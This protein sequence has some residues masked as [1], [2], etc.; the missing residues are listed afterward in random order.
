MSG[1]LSVHNDDSRNC[2]ALDRK[3]FQIIPSLISSQKPH[4]ESSHLDTIACLV[5][6]HTF[7]CQESEWCVRQRYPTPERRL[8]CF[9]GTQ[10]TARLLA[11]IAGTLACNNCDGRCDAANCLA[12]SALLRGMSR[13]AVLRNLTHAPHVN[14]SDAFSSAHRGTPM[15]RRHRPKAA[16]MLAG[17]LKRCAA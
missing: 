10:A 7:S 6:A 12:I 13:I 16:P 1:R 8:T 4:P 17:A 14:F 2:L 9:V 15:T 11:R 3:E 5:F